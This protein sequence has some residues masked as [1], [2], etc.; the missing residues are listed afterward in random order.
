M[1][2]QNNHL[3]LVRGWG[4]QAHLEESIG[5]GDQNLLMRVL[6]AIDGYNTAT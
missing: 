4:E 6:G 1:Q 2:V 3:G 5:K